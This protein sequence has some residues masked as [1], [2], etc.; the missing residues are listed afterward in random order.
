MTAPRPKGNLPVGR[1]NGIFIAVANRNLRRAHIRPHQAVHRTAARYD[2]AALP[3]DSFLNIAAAKIG[4]QL[5][6]T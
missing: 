4:Y 5:R 1:F 3:F 2:K 6:L